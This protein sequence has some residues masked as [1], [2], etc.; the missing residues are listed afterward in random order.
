[1]EIF[2]LQ[3]FHR[4]QRPH[5]HESGRVDDG[6]GGAEL[7]QPRLGLSILLSDGE[8][9]HRAITFRYI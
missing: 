6:T 5:R 1:M 2:R 4:P 7:S 9:H 8:L 3:P